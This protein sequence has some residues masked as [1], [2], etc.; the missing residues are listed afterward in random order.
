MLEQLVAADRGPGAFTKRLTL[1]RHDGRAKKLACFNVRLKERIHLRPDLIL[2]AIVPVNLRSPSEV[3]GLGNRFGLVWLP[4]PVG[5]ADPVERLR[6][7]KAAMDHIK[8]TPEANMVLGLLGVFGRT[9][10]GAVHLAVQFLAR[11]ATLVFT[12]VP[13]PRESVT[14]CG[15]RLKELMAWVPQSGRL[16]LGMSV[17]SY[18]GEIRLGVA[19][20]ASLVRDPDQLVRAYDRSLESV[21]DHAGAHVAASAAG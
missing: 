16:G 3:G 5:L 4:L 20:D 11:G 7:V 18:A 15:S 13:G 1:G 17:I 2:R 21:L 10:R 19:T 9:T 8:S 6:A 12:N 14:F